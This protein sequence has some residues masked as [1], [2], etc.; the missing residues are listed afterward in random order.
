MISVVLGT[1]L[2]NY[3]NPNTVLAFRRETNSIAERLFILLYILNH[4]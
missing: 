3:F 4:K 2:A 1:I